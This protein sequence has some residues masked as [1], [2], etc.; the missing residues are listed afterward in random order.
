[1]HGDGNG[2]GP[3][4]LEKFAAD[5]ETP[6]EMLMR[7]EILDRVGQAVAA[8]PALYRHVVWLRASAD[9]SCTEIGQHLGRSANAVEMLYRRA[10]QRIRWRLSYAMT[11]ESRRTVRLG[12]THECSQQGGS[13]F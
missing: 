1:V 12:C 5:I 11:S 2:S 8:L 13:V 4:F 6:P 7:Q 9:L 10:L 3:D